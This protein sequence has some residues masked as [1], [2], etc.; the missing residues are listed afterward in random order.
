MSVVQPSRAPG[1]VETGT[2]SFREIPH[3]SRLFLDYLYD[4][5]KVEKWY[6]RA[7]F[8]RDWKAAR[9]AISAAAYPAGRRARIA[10]VLER[11]NREFGAGAGAGLGAGVSA[12]SNTLANLGRF[13]AGS[14]VV[15]T[16]QQVG[17]FGGP[18]YCLL[19]ALTAVKLAAEATAAGVDTVPIFW[20]AAE[21]HDLA[22][23]NHTYLASAVGPGRIEV[24]SK[25]QPDAPVGSIVFGGEIER[26]VAEAAEALHGYSAG[27]PNVAEDEI[28][29]ALRACYAPGETFASAYGKLW[30]KLT[31]HW[32]LII[33]DASDPE[34][35]RVAQPL[36]VQAVER[37]SEINEALLARGKEL[38]R[39]GY[40]A[41]VKV[42][43]TSTPLF[44]MRAG[45]R[46]VIHRS[47][48]HS[49]EPAFTAGEQW[50]TP[51]ELRHLADHSPEMLSPNALFRPV[52]QDYLLP[53][54]AYVGGGA[55]IAYFAQSAVIFDALLGR[56][57]MVLPRIS[58]TLIEA[59]AAKLLDRYAVGL[60]DLLVGS[61][62]LAQELAKRELPGKLQDAFAAVEAAARLASQELHA[63]LQQLDATLTGAAQTASW[64]MA[65]QLNKLRERAARAELRRNEVL[66]RQAKLL[67]GNLYPFG[68][69]QERTLSGV[70]FVARHG[71]DWLE[72][73]TSALSV[74]T[75]D[76]QIVRV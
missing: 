42:T 6:A 10:D 48:P 50:F 4:F 35:D 76:H 22:E 23:V 30:T 40:H 62:V 28:L 15:V 73:L 49:G 24:G 61:G 39:A 47:H 14:H 5:A 2:L 33:L 18:L 29:A 43:A 58:A 64:K 16:G 72:E 74:D 69:L 45:V 65:Y 54:L 11:Q 59:K 63:Q 27:G 31:G 38:E 56:R 53:T 13:R 51:A 26:A 46:L 55:E 67:A 41:Q 1:A 75:P 34:L 71:F 36:Y 52:V 68:G 25:G 32:G 7:P 20:L 66:E 17:L 44:S 8:A 37:A 9:A 12:S 60:P 70:E 3:T 21:D 57:T 19:K